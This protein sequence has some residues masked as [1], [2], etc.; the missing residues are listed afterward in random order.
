MQS[1][2]ELSELQFTKLSLITFPFENPTEQTLVELNIHNKPLLKKYEKNKEE[3]VSDVDFENELRAWLALKRDK[4]L[5]EFI[6]GINQEIE[7]LNH[8]IEQYNH[9]DTLERKVEL[10]QQI[11]QKNSEIDACYP[12]SVITRCPEYLQQ[13]Y[14]RLNTELQKNTEQLTQ[15]HAGIAP[16]NYKYRLSELLE[17]MS[18]EKLNRFLELLCD[19]KFYDDELDDLYQPSDPEYAEFKEF[20]STHTINYSGGHNSANF[21]IKRMKSDELPYVLKLENRINQPKN[22][23]D[24]LRK[25]VDSIETAEFAR[26]AYFTKTGRLGEQTIIVRTVKMQSFYPDGSLLD[27]ATSQFRRGEK[28]KSAVTIYADMA[29]ILQKIARA[30]GVFPDMKNSNW[31]VQN[32][33]LLIADDKSFRRKNT[34]GTIDIFSEHSQWYGDVV[35][36]P[37]FMP[38]ERNEMAPILAEPFHVYTWGKNLYEYLTTNSNQNSLKLEEGAD[39]D[40]SDPIFTWDPEGPIFQ[41]LIKDT[42]C[43]DPNARISL[44]E[45]INRLERIPLLNALRNKIYVIS[46]TTLPSIVLSQYMQTIAS[47]DNAALEQFTKN[48]DTETLQTTVQPILA[49]YRAEYQEKFAKI[50]QE[51]SKILEKCPNDD[52]REAILAA[53]IEHQ[54]VNLMSYEQFHADLDSILSEARQLLQIYVDQSN[55]GSGR[56]HGGI[57]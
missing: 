46:P 19:R 31:M 57:L 13:F 2:V 42:V 7:G 53:K 30:G 54:S 29:N 40:F 48:L 39:F 6:L 15:L 52:L 18:Q 25:A 28:V 27:Y 1:S 9:E 24:E 20:L 3:G 14:N 50:F 12:E 11:K 23:A 5:H 8:L 44:Q 26:R 4:S 47:L 34:D 33:K 56:T 35:N 10:L 41:Q 38:P 37:Y 16:Q 22:I 17:K 51:L 49:A 36:T 32:G 43:A 21:Y 45:C 55:L